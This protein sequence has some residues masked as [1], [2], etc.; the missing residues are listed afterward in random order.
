ML[1][2]PRQP[3]QFSD[4]HLQS[5]LHKKASVKE[6]KA[7]EQHPDM[8]SIVPYPLA[9]FAMRSWNCLGKM[10][11]NNLLQE[12][13]ILKAAGSISGGCLPSQNKQFS[14]IYPFQ[15]HS[16]PHL[17]LVTTMGTHQLFSY[18]SA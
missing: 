7:T 14:Y 9:L 16:F 1:T 5:S 15:L 3:R 11:I 2:T 4:V 12:C 6:P 10:T 17:S 13:G 18:Y 8:L